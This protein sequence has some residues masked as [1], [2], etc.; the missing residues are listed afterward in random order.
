MLAGCRATLQRRKLEERDRKDCFDL[1]QKLSTRERQVLELTAEGLV[2]KEI[3]RLLDLSVRTVEMY[4]A[5]VKSKAGVKN[6]QTAIQLVSR[7]RQYRPAAFEDLMRSA[8]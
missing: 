1:L 3:A 6:L 2:N 7:V 4:R 8:S 5:N